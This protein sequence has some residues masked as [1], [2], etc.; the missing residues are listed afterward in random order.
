MRTTKNADDIIDWR[1]MESRL[2]KVED[3]LISVQTI[4]NLLID[5]LERALPPENG[6]DNDDAESEEA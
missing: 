2:R 3:A 4:V 1:I 6:A 5:L